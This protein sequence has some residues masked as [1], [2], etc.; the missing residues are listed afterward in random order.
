VDIPQA[1]V[2]AALHTAKTALT[3]EKLRL[4]AGV[5]SARL[6]KDIERLSYDGMI[7]ACNDS[8]GERWQLSKIGRRW[9]A[10]PSGR[11]ALEVPKRG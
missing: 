8:D 9:V 4:C 6:R 2:M 7:E 1:R 11:S 3:V 10:T 5:D